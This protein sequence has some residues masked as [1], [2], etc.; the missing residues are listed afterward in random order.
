M[1]YVKQNCIH[2]LF[3]SF[4]FLRFV[5]INTKNPEWSFYE[6]MPPKY[7]YMFEKVEELFSS[8]IDLLE[9][10]EK[11]DEIVKSNY[12]FWLQNWELNAYKKNIDKIINEVIND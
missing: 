10:K 5:K 1:L 4:R 9:N 11:R 3:Y 2:Y 6:Y 8:I 7:P 12:E